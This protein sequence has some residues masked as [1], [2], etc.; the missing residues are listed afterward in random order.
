MPSMGET[1]TYYVYIMTNKSGTLYTGVTNSI[2]RRVRQHKDKLVAGFARKYNI[3]RLIYYECFT[4]V[5]AAIAREKTIKG[6]L[7]AK[8]LALIASVNPQWQDLSEEWYD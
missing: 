6:W 1:R 8:K 5:R 4:D 2:R 7:R 3:D